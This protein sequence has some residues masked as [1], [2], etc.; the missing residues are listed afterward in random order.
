M[1]T[2]PNSWFMYPRVKGEAEVELKNK[3]LDWLTIIKPALIKNRKNPR[4]V[5]K[6]F[7]MIPLIP[8]IESREVAL[9]LKTLAER[10][11]EAAS[12]SKEGVKVLENK[13]L[14]NLLKE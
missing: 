9:S 12:T 10:D 1:G 8:K 13:D 3:K 11:R 4:T 6:I 5:E 7:G 14:L 2:N